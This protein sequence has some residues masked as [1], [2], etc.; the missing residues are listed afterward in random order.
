MVSLTYRTQDLVNID[1]ESFELDA[2]LNAIEI[3]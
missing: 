1:S 2:F 3:F